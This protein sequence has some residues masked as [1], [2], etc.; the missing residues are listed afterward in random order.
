MMRRYGFAHV[1]VS[2]LTAANLLSSLPFGMINAMA[3]A[4]SVTASQSAD[5][6]SFAERRECDEVFPLPED[7]PNWTNCRNI[8]Q[9][10]CGGPAECQCLPEQRLVTFKCDQGTYQQCFGEKGNGCGQ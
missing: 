6:L 3:F 9:S 4:E 2:V 5:V 8:G 7:Y 1:L 10:A